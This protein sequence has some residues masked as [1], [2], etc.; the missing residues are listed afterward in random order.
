MA[1]LT[2]RTLVNVSSWL[3]CVTGDGRYLRILSSTYALLYYFRCEL[4]LQSF[5]TSVLPF[6]WIYIRSAHALISF[7][8]SAPNVS[9]V[10]GVATGSLRQ[11]STSTYLSPLELLTI[12]P[13]FCSW[14]SYSRV[15][16]SCLF[17]QY[18][19]YPYPHL[20]HLAIKVSHLYC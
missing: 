16:L 10:E 18:P 9:S 11:C 7:S 5:W 3:A 6:W 13:F 20:I 14:C 8:M 1:D 19:F 17:A 12:S 2:D 15:C 4:S